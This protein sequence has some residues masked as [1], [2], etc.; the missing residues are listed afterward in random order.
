ML[1]AWITPHLEGY[2][3]SEVRLRSV[4]GDQIEA[5][6]DLLHL[7]THAPKLGSLAAFR[8]VRMDVQAGTLVLSIEEVDM[9]ARPLSPAG[10]P[11]SIS[12]RASLLD[13]ATTDALLI[14]DLHI[15]GE[16]ILRPIS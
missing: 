4:A 1:I 11:R 8:S 14:R 10:V 16:S 15:R 7:V 13:Y 5:A 12:S 9:H 3:T 6:E 2:C